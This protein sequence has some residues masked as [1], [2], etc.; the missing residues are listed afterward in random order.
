MYL[1]GMWLDVHLRPRKH[2]FKE[3]G[4]HFHIFLVILESI[5]NMIGGGGCGGGILPLIEHVNL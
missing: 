4:L 1:S 2:V 3:I 5:F